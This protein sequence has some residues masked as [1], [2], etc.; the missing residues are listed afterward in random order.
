MTPFK[1]ISD[2]EYSCPGGIPLLLDLYLPLHARRPAAAV[3]WV[4]GGGWGH[5]DRKTA[6]LVL[7]EHGF[8]MASLM[9]R[10]TSQAVAPA[11]I[12]DCKAAVRWL[13]ANAAQ[14]GID[15]HRI[16]AWGSSAG[17]HLVALL[18][19][20][21]GMPDLE[22]N[23]ENAGQ[24]SAV[25]AVCDFC[26]PTDLA[27]MAAPDIQERHPHLEGILE[28]Y[29]GGPVTRYQ[30]LARLV[31]PLSH[32]SARCAPMLIV[33]GEADGTVPVGE[34][35]MFYKALQAAG[36]DAVLHVLPEVGHG[37][38]ARLTDD[39]VVSFFKTKLA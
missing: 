36:A 33:H 19:T 38:D 17:G 34:S 2:L 12:H 32:V 29:L 25:Q 39:L 31:S 13:R 37:W 6:P 22:G 27:Q 21:D 1:A 9:Y 5:C 8:V 24:S 30:K 4:P 14:H 7:L 3:L 10:T 23:G 26:G 18:G 20:T 16:G 15:P 28:A 11:N 35:R